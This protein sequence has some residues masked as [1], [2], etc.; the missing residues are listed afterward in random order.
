MIFMEV[1]R[2]F[3]AAQRRGRRGATMRVPPQINTKLLFVLQCDLI[4]PRQCGSGVLLKPS[5][6]LLRINRS[7]MIVE[8]VREALLI[9]TREIEQAAG[10]NFVAVW[11]VAM[12]Q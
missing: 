7:T 4:D 9:V 10:L 6:S 12:G 2:E 5:A 3:Q 11:N 1:P 8:G